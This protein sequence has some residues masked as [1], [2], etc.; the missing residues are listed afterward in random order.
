MASDAELLALAKK[1]S[2]VLILTEETGHKWGDI[3]V[4]KPEPVGIMGATSADNMWFKIGDRLVQLSDETWF[5]STD[6]ASNGKTWEPR[7]KLLENKFAFFNGL[8]DLTFTA[9]VGSDN[10]NRDESYTLKDAHFNF[11]GTGTNVFLIPRMCIYT[12]ELSRSTR[13]RTIPSPGQMVRRL[14]QSHLDAGTYQY[15]RDSR[16]EQGRPVSSGVYLYHLPVAGAPRCLGRLLEHPPIARRRP[17]RGS[18]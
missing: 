5:N 2:P 8:E 11:S 13:I 1:F 4:L 16:D 15:G 7:I 17:T 12:R 10:M 6:V 14:I 18:R 3:K 9:T